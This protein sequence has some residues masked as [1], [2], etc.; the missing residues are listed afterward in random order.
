M[1]LLGFTGVSLSIERIYTCK[2]TV[3][4][5]LKYCSSQKKIFVDE[6]SEMVLIVIY[7]KISYPI[8]S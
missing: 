3:K 2:H 4:M 5:E 7:V 6:I 1:R 8:L